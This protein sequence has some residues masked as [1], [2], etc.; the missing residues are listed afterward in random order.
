MPALLAAHE[1]AFAHFGGRCETL[2]YGRMRT[3]SFL[4]TEMSL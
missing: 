1:N 4:E 3:V 2:R